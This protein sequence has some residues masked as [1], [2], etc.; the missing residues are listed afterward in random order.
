MRSR[1]LATAQYRLPETPTGLPALPKSVVDYCGHEVDLTA[2]TWVT[3]RNIDKRGIVQINVDLL[4]RPRDFSKM[5]S[6]QRLM[7]RRSAIDEALTH[8][9][10]M[11][12]VE[13][14]KTHAPLSADKVLHGFVNFEKYLNESYRWGVHTRLPLTT[15][16]LTYEV[17]DS[18]NRWIADNNP[19]HVKYISF[20][21]SFYSFGLRHSLPGFVRSEGKKIKNIRAKEPLRGHIARFR[22]PQ[23]GALI[24]EEEQQVIGALAKDKG[25][26]HDRALVRLFHEIGIRLEA[27]IRIRRKYLK[28]TPDPDSYFLYVPRVKQRRATLELKEYIISAELASLLLSL[29]P[30]D[31]DDD[32]FLLHWLGERGFSAAVSR[33]MT[34]WV[35]EAGLKTR[36]LNGG[37][38]TPLPLV[39]YRFRR[40]IATQMAEDGA[41]PEEIAEFLDDK[42]TAM[43]AVYVANSSNIVEVLSQ[44]L[45]RHPAW[46]RLIGLFQGRLEVVD[47]QKLPEILGGVPY[48]AEY[49]MFAKRIDSI[50]RCAKRSACQLWPPLSCY[51]CEFF[52]PTR[53]KRPHEIQLDQIKRE[54]DSKL[55]R[56][57][58]RL[59]GIFRSTMAAILSV[60]AIIRE[61]QGISARGIGERARVARHIARERKD[62][63]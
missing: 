36:R 49:E 55:G 46:F 45:D 14:L 31:S 56:E 5:G 21:R 60:V 9:M 32:T 38:I 59:V 23:K 15:S 35:K 61:S 24:W 43:A 29:L 51:S 40:T 63:S 54:I 2:T 11:F 28:P 58:D 3:F 25:E 39:P 37:R 27:A 12:I 26:A 30:E 16:T 20:L 8:A 7:R 57:S 13:R 10:C 42:S 44:T 52:R 34:R 62:G 1:T 50:G 47:D 6:D 41:T 22:D 4:Y 33:A 19:F 53:D 17:V 48:L 18:Y